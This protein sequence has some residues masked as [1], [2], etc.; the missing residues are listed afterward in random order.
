MIDW[1][2]ID[3]EENFSCCLVY[4]DGRYILLYIKIERILIDTGWTRIIQQ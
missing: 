3:S 2:G 4:I 1:R